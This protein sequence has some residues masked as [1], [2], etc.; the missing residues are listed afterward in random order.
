[1]A[2]AVVQAVGIPTVAD[3]GGCYS[4]RVPG[5]VGTAQPGVE[6][7]SGPHTVAAGEDNTL[8][9]ASVVVEEIHGGHHSMTVRLVVVVKPLSMKVLTGDL[10]YLATAS[11]TD[12]IDARPTRCGCT[13]EAGQM[14][15]SRS[16]LDDLG[17][18]L[19]EEP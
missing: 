10:D 5:C 9:W 2:A 7:P 19:V 11:G 16:C 13:L 6:T 4:C 1:M 8:S 12:R 14:E 15:D 17:R 18:K 3:P